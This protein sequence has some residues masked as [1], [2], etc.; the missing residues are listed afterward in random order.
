MPPR[1]KYLLTIAKDIAP[2]IGGDINPVEAAN[3]LRAAGWGDLEEDHD[4]IEILEIIET[5]ELEE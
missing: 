4:L 3:I 5:A 2:E 1:L